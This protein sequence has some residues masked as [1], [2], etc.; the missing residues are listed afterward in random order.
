MFKICEILAAGAYGERV[1]ELKIKYCLPSPSKLKF[2]H[3]TFLLNLSDF[4]SIYHKSKSFVRQNHF[5]ENKFIWIFIGM[6]YRDEDPVFGK[7]TGSGT[8][9]LK[10]RKILKFYLMNILDNFNSFLSC[11]HT[12]G[13]WHIIDVLYSENQSGSG[14]IRTGYGSKTKTGSSSLTP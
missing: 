10:R 2:Q 6:S 9:Y 8:L 7:K 13:A 3:L 1:S 4:F 5:L 12:F 11:F 14:K